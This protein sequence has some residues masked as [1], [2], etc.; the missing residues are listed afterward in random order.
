[1]F[2]MARATHCLL[3]LRSSPAPASEEFLVSAA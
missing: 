1:M 3:V 2:M